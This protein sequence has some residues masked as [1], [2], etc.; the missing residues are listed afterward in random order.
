MLFSEDQTMGQNT[1]QTQQTQT[2]EDWLA[3]VVE[4]KGE[5]FK[6]VQVLAKSKLD[7]DNYI[8]QLEEQLA[9]A[10]EDMSKQDYAAKLLEQL[11]NKGAASTTANPVAPKD[12]NSGSNP[13]D[14]KPVISEDIIKALV[15]QT[16]TQREKES[17]ASQNIQTVQAELQTK[18]GTGAKD[19]V[20]AKAKELGMT[21]DRL[22]EIASESPTAFFTLIGEP[23][24]EFKPLTQG[25]INTAAG[26]FSAPSNRDWNYYENIRKTNKKLYY[27]PKTQQQMFQ[28]KMRLGD[29]FGN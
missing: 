8:K 7:A 11:Q 6:D 13:S 22:S 5:N 24:K 10:R 21:Y 19:H 29:R 17:T 3:K 28:D 9:K 1:N 16:L 14:T 25:T 18:Y 15:E 2:T 4:A 23:K 27:D 20:L 26:T 12:N